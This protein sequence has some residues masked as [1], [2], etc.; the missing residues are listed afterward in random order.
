[1]RIGKCEDRNKELR[2]VIKDKDKCKDVSRHREK[3]REERVGQTKQLTI[4][5]WSTSTRPIG[6]EARPTRLPGEL[7]H[8]QLAR[9]ASLTQDESNSPSRRVGAPLTR[10]IGGWTRSRT[11]SP[12]AV[13]AYPTLV[14]LDPSETTSPSWR[15]GAL[16]TRPIGELGQKQDELANLASWDTPNSPSGSGA[17]GARLA[18]PR[19]RQ[20]QAARCGFGAAGARSVPLA[21]GRPLRIGAAAGM[22]AAARRVGAAGRLW[23]RPSGVAGRQA[24]WLR[25]WPAPVGCRWR[26]AARWTVPLC[27]CQAGLRYWLKVSAGTHPATPEGEDIVIRERQL[28]LERRQVP[29]LVI[30]SA[31]RRSSLWGRGGG[32]ATRASHQSA[33]IARSAGNLAAALSNLNLKVFP[34]DGT[35][36]P[37]EPAEVIEN[38]S[39]GFLKHLPALS[40][41]GA[42]VPREPIGQSGRAGG[43]EGSTFEEKTQRIARELEIRDLKDKIKEVERTAEISSADALSA[44]KKSLELEEVMETLRFEMVMAVNRARVVAHSRL[45]WLQRKSDKWDLTKALEQYKTVVLEEAKNRNA[46]APTFEDEP[47]IPPGSRM[48]TGRASLQPGASRVGD[49]RPAP[50]ARRPVPNAAWR[51]PPCASPTPGAKLRDKAS[52]S[53]RQARP[54]DWRGQPTARAEHQRVTWRRARNTARRQY[55]VASAPAPSPA[56]PGAKRVMKLTCRPARVI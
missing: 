8:F 15:V 21:P 32:V 5:W 30:D 38:P 50:S 47:V 44:G 40:S 28:P 29:F 18:P 25:L 48:D 55:S 22:G 3:E 10:P 43:A 46:P 39:R 33:E 14:E 34:H 45:K 27:R 56:Q 13:G 11:T 24:V 23:L 54:G 31:L 36:L 19:R 4:S 17:D 16:P 12:S 52:C 35:T 6:E 42:V 1:M 20:R 2:K 41:W 49:L 37:W 53:R 9:L 7:E 26:Q 51:L